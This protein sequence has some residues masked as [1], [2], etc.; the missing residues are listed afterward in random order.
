MPLIAITGGIA[1][2]KTTF[3]RQLGSTLPAA[4]FDT[5]QCARRLLTDDQEVAQTVRTTFG[6]GVFDDEGKIDR[7]I[8]RGII[9]GSKDS[10]HKLEAILHPRVRGLWTRWAQD[11]LQNAPEAILLVEIPLLYETAAANL[12][13]QV[14]VVGCAEETQLRRLT[15]E[16]R[17]SID[18]ARQIIASQ[19][20]LIDK[21]RSGDRLIWNDGSGEG[22]RMQVD[23]CA[24][25]L[26]DIYSPLRKAT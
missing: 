18:I 12:F 23:F 20:P 17:L 9:F 21:I 22:L 3:T 7:G 2:G 14:I 10:R 15:T 8:L 5:D 16:R 24:R 19:W 26:Q 25:Y 4:I 6:N 1:A 11:Q 13:D